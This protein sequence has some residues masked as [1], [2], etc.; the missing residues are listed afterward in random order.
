MKSDMKKGTFCAICSALVFGTTPVLASITFAMGSN[1]MTLTFYRNIMAAPV[2]L[3]ILLIRKVDLRVTKKELLS[4]LLISAALNA[5][6][7]Y[8]LY[9]AYDYI[10]IGLSTT[11]HFL[12]PMFAVLFGRLFFKEKLD[13]VKILALILATAGVAV[14]TGNSDSF[15]MKGIILSLASAI[16]YSTYM[17]SVERTAVNQMD[18]MKAMFYMCIFNAIVVGIFD[19]PKGNIVYAL[20]P[21]VLWYTFILAVINSA[22]AHVLLILGI[23]LIGAGNAAIFSMLEPVSGVV[24]GFLFLGEGLP[25]M[26]LISCI[27][28]LAAVMLPIIKDRNDALKAQNDNLNDET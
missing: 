21:T 13:K 8:L 4:L 23:K 14:A 1:A 12:Y 19:L 6:T 26:K 15:A 20:E 18:S 17:V 5:P 7:T 3:L 11:L 28:I 25:M 16:T 27:I 22:F 9:A 10:G 24:A 2:M